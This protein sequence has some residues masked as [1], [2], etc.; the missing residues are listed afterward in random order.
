M[1][2]LALVAWVWSALVPCGCGAP[3][4][5][6][7][8]AS[9]SVSLESP[10]YV[11]IALTARVPGASFRQAGAESVTALVR[12]DGEPDSHIVLYGGGEETPYRAVSTRR[13]AAGAHDV[14]VELDPAK[15]RA[16]EAP[17]QIT[18]LAVTAAQDADLARAPILIGRDGLDSAS[19]DV[20][21][22]MYAERE[23]GGTRYTVIWSNEDGGTGV[24]P[25]LLLSGYGRVVD[26]EWVYEIADGAAPPAGKIQGAGHGTEPFSGTVVGERPVLLTATRNNNMEGWKRPLLPQEPQALVFSLPLDPPPRD[27]LRERLLDRHPA[28]VRASNDELHREHGVKDAPGSAAPG[29]A[30]LREHFYVDYEGRDLPEGRVIIVDEAGRRAASDRGVAI[31]RVSGSQLRT[32]IE[33]AAPGARFAALELETLGGAGPADP[34]AAFRV[35]TL[36]D[37]FAPVEVA[38]VPAGQV[39]VAPLR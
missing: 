28:W 2:Q 35:F 27:G 25:S 4:T 10:A 11:E 5:P 14:R 17:V 39:K 31:G 36:D 32:A 15:S 1:N 22:G 18:R 16:P 13:L 34:A 8:P 30:D 21:L 6:D 3:S 33:R 26:I 37:A 19:T 7:L 20:P 12:V 9:T 38:R 29:V 24:L 23:A